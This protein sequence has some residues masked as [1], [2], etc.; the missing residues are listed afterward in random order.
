MSA[1]INPKFVTDLPSDVQK[2]V[3]NYF[4]TNDLNS[5][6]RVSKLWNH[7]FASDTMWEPI[8]DQFNIKK[9]KKQENTP[10]HQFVL[11]SPVLNWLSEPLK[12]IILNTIPNNEYKTLVY[13]KIKADMLSNYSK[14]FVKALGGPFAVNRLPLIHVTDDDTSFSATYGIAQEYFSAPIVRA[15]LE[16]DQST[17]HFILFRIKDNSKEKLYRTALHFTAC[18]TDA[19]IIGNVHGCDDM[20]LG[21][22]CTTANGLKFQLNRL[23]R[24]VQKKPVGVLIEDHELR[25]FGMSVNYSEGPTVTI[26]GQSILELC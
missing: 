10:I 11:N 19:H 16:T 7:L 17:E 23:Q 24:L 13:K 12:F 25:P 26:S 18:D 22:L 20:I 8:A 1:T 2:L 6:M 4:T 3:A 9:I 21:C 14:E 5:C 15:V